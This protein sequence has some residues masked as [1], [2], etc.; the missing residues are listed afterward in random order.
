MY[1]HN[2]GD[3]GTFL[4]GLVTAAAVVIAFCA[5]YTLRDSGIVLGAAREQA[6]I[7]QKQ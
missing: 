3:D 6:T 2:R 1:N 4:M 7:Q 5:G